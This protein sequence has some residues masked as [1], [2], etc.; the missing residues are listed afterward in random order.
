MLHLVNLINGS[1]E[2][3][4]D[5]ALLFYLSSSSSLFLVTT[6]QFSVHLTG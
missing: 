6:E 1:L 5:V 2:T 3:A 4:L